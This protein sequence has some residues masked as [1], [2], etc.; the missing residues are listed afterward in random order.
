MGHRIRCYKTY[1]GNKHTEHSPPPTFSL[2]VAE[3]ARAHGVSDSEKEQQEQHGLRLVRH[4]HAKKVS[5]EN[6]PKQGACHYAQA[7]TF[8][9]QPSNEISDADSQVHG[10]FRV[11]CKH[12][13]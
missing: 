8:K 4:W 10:H 1:D 6:S 13:A 9:L 3:E 2:E 5:D 7:N 11:F 12:T